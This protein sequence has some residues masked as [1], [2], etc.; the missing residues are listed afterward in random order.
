MDFRLFSPGRT[1]DAANCKVVGIPR[2]PSHGGLRK[3][4]SRTWTECGGHTTHKKNHDRGRPAPA[5]CNPKLRYQQLKTL[6]IPIQRFDD[7][8]EDAS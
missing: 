2:N 6:G 7:S 1:I 4:V 5:D 3:P 8:I